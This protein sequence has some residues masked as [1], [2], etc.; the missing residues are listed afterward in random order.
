MNDSIY[1]SK[2]GI[3]GGTN[4]RK[5][6]LSRQSDLTATNGHFYR[7]NYQSTTG[8]SAGTNRR[9]MRNLMPRTRLEELVPLLY[10]YIGWR[11]FD[12]LY[13]YEFFKT[14]SKVTIKT[15]GKIKETIDSSKI[16]QVFL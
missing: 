14:T 13:K 5:S 12:L 4:R 9:K 6:T 11:E 16:V 8:I 3:S 15:V 2:T 7:M 10:I 1:Q